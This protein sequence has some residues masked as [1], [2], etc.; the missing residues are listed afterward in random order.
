[1]GFRVCDSCEFPF[2]SFGSNKCSRCELKEQQEKELKNAR[3]LE[4]KKTDSISGGKP[5]NL[6]ELPK[7]ADQK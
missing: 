6:Q 3:K 1:M 2:I 7:E 4:D 5:E